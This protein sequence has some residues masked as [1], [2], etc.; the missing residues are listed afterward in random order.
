MRGDAGWGLLLKLQTL[1]KSC[2]D[3]KPIVKKPKAIDI[4]KFRRRSLPSARCH[5]RFL[6]QHGIWVM[7]RGQGTIGRIGKPRDKREYLPLKGM[8]SS[9]TSKKHWSMSF[10]IP[11]TGSA[12]TWVIMDA[13]RS[14]LVGEF[15]ALCSGNC[16]S[17]L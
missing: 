10:P 11:A 13:G 3:K 16:G 1:E 5:E 7:T 17:G 6:W 14:E 12:F 4:S 8:A 9:Y 15:P 2:R